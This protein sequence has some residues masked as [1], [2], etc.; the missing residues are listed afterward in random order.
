MAKKQKVTASS[1]GMKLIE[2]QDEDEFEGFADE[3]PGFPKAADWPSQNIE[4]GWEEV[5]K[6]NGSTKDD[7]EPMPVNEEPVQLEG[8]KE[9]QAKVLEAEGEVA[10]KAPGVPN[11]LSKDW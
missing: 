9:K 2:V 3:K 4:E 8:A 6:D 7:R 11:M 5:D 10:S 1:D